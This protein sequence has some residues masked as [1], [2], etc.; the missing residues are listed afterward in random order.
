MHG[1]RLSMSVALL[2]SCVSFF[3]ELC[4]LCGN[5]SYED[6]IFM[7]FDGTHSL[8]SRVETKKTS[9]PV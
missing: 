2:P 3:L 5:L 1:Y 9:F 7:T 6:Q 8:S 4:L